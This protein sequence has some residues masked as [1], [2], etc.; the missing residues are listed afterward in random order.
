LAELSIRHT[1][2]WGSPSSL[3]DLANISSPTDPID[4]VYTIEAN[5][6]IWLIA[7]QRRAHFTARDNEECKCQVM[8][9]P[10]KVGN[11]LLPNI[12]IRPKVTPK[13]ADK[14]LSGQSQGQGHVEE[15]E[16]LNCET[17]YLSYGECVMV[18]PDVKSTTVGIGEM[19]S[20]KSAVW[21]ESTGR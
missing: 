15:E 11:I 14:R 7:G 18:I 1:R 2:R 6:D 13:D 3:I 17:D 10:L 19:G 12:E 16:Q 8:L 20:S 5:P 21:L 4:F 9:V